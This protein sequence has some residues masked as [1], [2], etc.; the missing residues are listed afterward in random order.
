MR[1]R[2]VHSLILGSGPSGLAAG[3]TVAKAGHKPIILERDK[4]P[5]GLMRSVRHGE[6]VVDV[7]RKELYNRLAKVEE[8]W[9]GIL[10]SDYRQ[11]PHRGGYLYKGRIFEVSR[12]FRGVRRGMPLPTWIGCAIDLVSARL[13]PFGG[14][15]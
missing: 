10:G 5:G 4:T 14:K 2:D 3:Y 1:T 13:N 6:F 12:S 8:F 11:Y 9:S 15:P 7:G